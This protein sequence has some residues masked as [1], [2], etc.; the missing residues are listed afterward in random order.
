MSVKN[1]VLLLS[2]VLL[3]LS[4]LVIGL[5]LYSVPALPFAIIN[6]GDFHHVLWN[7]RKLDTI[8]Q[9]VLIFSAAM[10]ILVF[11]AERNKQ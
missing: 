11:F 10:G 9:A 7:F 8:V 3:L 6:L 2:A 5:S 1:I 4:F